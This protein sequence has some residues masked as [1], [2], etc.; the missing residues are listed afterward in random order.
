MCTLHR[1]GKR[2]IAVLEK[3]VYRDIK[4]KHYSAIRDQ[5]LLHYSYSF[6]NIIFFDLSMYAVTFYTI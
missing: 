5:T 1:E 4:G 6:I 2:Q 3:F